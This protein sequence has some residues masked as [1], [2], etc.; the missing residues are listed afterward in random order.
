[1]D[2]MNKKV[3]T[4]RTF[5]QKKHGQKN[6]GKVFNQKKKSNKNRWLI[7]IFNIVTVVNMKIMIFWVVM[8]YSLVGT[9]VFGEPAA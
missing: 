4:V 3:G 2:K 6:N 9:N 5:G 1:M 7:I 8:P